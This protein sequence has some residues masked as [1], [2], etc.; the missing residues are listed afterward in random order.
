MRGVRQQISQ[1]RNTAVN[2]FQVFAMPGRKIA[3]RR[4]GAKSG[5]LHTIVPTER[6]VGTYNRKSNIDDII[7]DIE[8][9]WSEQ[10]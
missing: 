5:P 6:L 2:G 10:E 4:V 8:A 7:A 1:G 3:V 9:A